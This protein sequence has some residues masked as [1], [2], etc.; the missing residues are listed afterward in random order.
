MHKHL[1]CKPV[2]QA[3][4]VPEMLLNGG[5]AIPASLGAKRMYLSRHVPVSLARRPC[6]LEHKHGSTR[7][8]DASHRQ[9]HEEY[10]ELL[11]VAQELLLK[12]ALPSATCRHMD[13][14]APH[15][16]SYEIL[17]LDWTQSSHCKTLQALHLHPA[18]V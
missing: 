15:F 16:A 4:P 12:L 9:L 6:A 3:S 2:L 7:L 17:P 11:I 14:A 8:E 5:C 1:S 13:T 10:E 18:A